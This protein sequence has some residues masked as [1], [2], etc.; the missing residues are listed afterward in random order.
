[1]KKLL[2]L[3]S[4]LTFFSCMKSTIYSEMTKGFPE[5]RWAKSDAR[6]FDFIIKEKANANILVKFSHIFEPQYTDVP[7]FVTVKKPTGDEVTEAVLLLKDSE[8]KNIS[9]CVGDVCDLEYTLK[10]NYD[11]EP[12]SYTIVIANTAKG[13]YLPNVL[14]LGIE[15]VAV[16]K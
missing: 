5:N 11:F 14:G 15:I 4:F 6:H 13:P 7:L 12:G 8:G 10:E 16:T 9:D 1:M 3:F 2:L